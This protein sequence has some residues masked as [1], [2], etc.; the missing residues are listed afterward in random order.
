[1]CLDTCVRAYGRDRLRLC[2]SC[3]TATT[4]GNYSSARNACAAARACLRSCDRPGSRA[5]A[6]GRTWT[7][8]TLKAEW[9]AR[10]SHTS[11]IDAAGA[12]YV[13]GGIG[14][15][16]FYHDV[17]ASTD[18]GTRPDSR[19]GG[20]SGG[21]GW[22]LTGTWHGGDLRSLQLG[23][24]WPRVRAGVCAIGFRCRARWQVSRGRAVLSRR[25]GLADMGTRP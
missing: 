1:M 16:A 9:A 12:I 21:T 3:G 23:L 4:F 19:R 7:S 13:I 17:W 15:D 22:V 8:R 10:E 6:A 2:A 5:L 25:R 14:G 11:V 20:W 18:G 24:R